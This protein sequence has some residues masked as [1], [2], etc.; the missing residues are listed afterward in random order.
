M[1]RLG[2]SFEV[3][4]GVLKCLHIAD[5]FIR[6]STTVSRIYQTGFLLVDHLIW[7]GRVGLFEINRD[8]WALTANR[9]WLGSIIINL[10]R[11][12]YEI[13]C[14]LGR[15][16]L[17]CRLPNKDGIRSMLPTDCSSIPTVFKPLYSTVPISRPVFKFAKEHPDVFWDCLKNCCDFWI[18]MTS[19]GHVKLSPGA[20]GLLGVISSTA[21]LI[22]VLDPLAKLAPT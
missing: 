9:L 2:K 12:L 22:T 10:V 21:G 17:P 7:S 19:L 5:P 11:D 15:K 3:L 16:T 6:M 1:L 4:Y 14:L 13:W 8:K 20:V 18:P